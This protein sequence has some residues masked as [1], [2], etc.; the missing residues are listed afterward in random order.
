MVSAPFLILL[1]FLD[2]IIFNPRSCSQVKQRTQREKKIENLR[3][4]TKCEMGRMI[5]KIEHMIFWLK[6]S[7]I[8][9]FFLSTSCSFAIHEIVLTLN[10]QE[11]TEIDLYLLCLSYHKREIL[12]SEPF[13]YIYG[14]F[15]SLAKWEA[16][17][18]RHHLYLCV[19]V[20]VHVAAPNDI[21]SSH[22]H[23]V[24]FDSILQDFS[25]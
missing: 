15:V 19:L 12:R 17:R 21:V 9:R 11:D 5:I 1:S 13:I 18:K 25:F 10:E 3:V 4:E 2:L 22:W 6:N 16:L 24:H 7:D 23:V 8:G 14:L 20:A